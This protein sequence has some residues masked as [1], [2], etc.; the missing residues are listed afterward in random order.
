MIGNG[1]MYVVVNKE[2]NMS[3]GKTAAQVAHA[4]SRLDV[5]VPKTTIILE[6]TTDQIRNLDIYLER[7]G[8][9]HHMY[10]DEGANEVP[11]MSAAA[12]AFGMVADDFTPDYIEGFE[13][14][15]DQTPYKL[16]HEKF[17]RALAERHLDYY[18]EQA[19]EWRKSY[20]KAGRWPWQR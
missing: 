7:M 2:L 5:G 20:M 17:C 1:K 16:E 4:V 18:K 12:L 15:V 19:E 13:L 9:P 8:I 6:G 14:Y 10:I 11:P 3:A